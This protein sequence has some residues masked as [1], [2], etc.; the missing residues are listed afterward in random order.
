[1]NSPRQ[2]SSASCG[3]PE[4]LVLMMLLG[5]FPTPQLRADFL[6]PR[7]HSNLWEAEGGGGG[8]VAL[9]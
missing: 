4:S 6:S 2:R 1:M 7:L 5:R 8:L 9:F 3:H